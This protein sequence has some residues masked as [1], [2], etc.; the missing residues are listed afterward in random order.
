MPNDLG[1]PGNPIAAPV[2]PPNDAGVPTPVHIADSQAR[3]V[4][5]TSGANKSKTLFG[6]NDSNKAH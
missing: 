2:K 3:D 1:V 6:N 4:V 5:D